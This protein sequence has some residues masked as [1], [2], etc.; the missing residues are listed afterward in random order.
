EAEARTG[1]FTRALNLLNAVRD[2]AISGTMESYTAASFANDN[3]LVQ[4]ILN[5]RRVEFLAE[6]MRWK[7]IHRNALDSNF[8]PD[9]IP[10]KMISSDVDGSTYAIGNT[11]L[12]KGVAAKSYSDHRF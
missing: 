2:R 1:G 8:G 12:T 5:E 4:G 6:G 3:A 11:S 10:A 7:D 9:G